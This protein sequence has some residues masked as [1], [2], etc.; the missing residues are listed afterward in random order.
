MKSKVLV[1]LILVVFLAGSAGAAGQDRNEKKIDRIQKKIE[2]QSKKLQ[3]L[4]GE[5]EH[6]YGVIAPAM[7]S[8]EIAKIRDEARAQANEAREQ[9]RESM[10]AQREAMQEQR[11]AM[12][13]QKKELENQMIIIRK[14]NAGKLGEMKALKLDKL[15]EL[16]ESEGAE[17]KVWSDGKGKNY[18][19]SFKTPKGET[20][21]GETFVFGEPGKVKV[22]IPELKGGVYSFYSGNRDNLSINKNLT[23]ES[24]TADFNYEVSKVPAGWR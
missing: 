23:D 18:S 10:E 11:E 7:N 4:T 12:M 2:K 3:E 22:E 24:S 19:Y 21:G 14:K 9:V 1:P 6:M 13:D 20:K 16:E 17:V 5:Q 15:R 8:E